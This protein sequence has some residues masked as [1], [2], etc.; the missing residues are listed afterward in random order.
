MDQIRQ[1]GTYAAVA[2]EQG[3]STAARRLGISPPAVTRLVAGLEHRLGVTLLKRTTRHVRTTEAGEQYL[4]DARRILAQ[5]DLADAAVAGTNTTP[6]GHLSVTAPV[7]FGR[8]YLL[9]IITKYLTDHP[10]TS[11]ST[12]FLDRNVSLVE[13]GVD[14]GLRIGQL[15]DSSLRALPVGEVSLVVVGAPQYLQQSPPINHPTDL[16]KHTLISSVAGN[17]AF[18]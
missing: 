4:Q 15:P 16:R 13:E 18:A 8:Q 9:P 12:L 6:R 10:E 5:L 14:I 3:F 2:E 11:V 7:L 1:L 17:N